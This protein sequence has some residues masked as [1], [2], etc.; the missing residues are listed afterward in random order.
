[1]C[2]WL[3]DMW[4]SENVW[5]LVHMYAAHKCVVAYERRDVYI[6]A[7]ICGHVAA[8]EHMAACVFVATT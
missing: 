6:P 8:C 5:L 3:I 1:M 4:L 2:G 7:A